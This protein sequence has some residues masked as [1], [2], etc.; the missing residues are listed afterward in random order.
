MPIQQ[1]EHPDKKGSLA[2]HLL[3]ATPLIQESCF[4]RSVVYMCAHNEAGAMGVIVN[5]GIDSI[6][7]ADVYSQLSIQPRTADVMPIHFGGPVEANRGFIL[8]S[9]EVI[10]EESAVDAHCGIALTASL[11]MLQ[12]IAAGQGPRD[13]MLLLGYAGWSA[14]QLESEIE[15]G[16]WMVVPATR[17]LVFGTD[18]DLKWSMAVSTL[19]FDIGHFSTDVGHA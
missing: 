8:H 17:Q 10:T 19:G 7:I 5:S 16:S 6:D 3:V 18:N 13:V 12:Q 9:N 14:Q 15:G 11:A 4:A 2:G 1:I